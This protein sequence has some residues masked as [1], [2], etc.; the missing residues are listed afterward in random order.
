MAWQN[1]QENARQQG[2][3]TTVGLR[4]GNPGQAFDAFEVSEDQPSLTLG[5][6]SLEFSTNHPPVANAGANK[7]VGSGAPFT[8]DGS[9]STDP[10]GTAGLLFQWTQ[11]AGPVTTIKDPN[12]AEAQVTGVKG[13]ATLTYQLRVIDPFGRASFDTVTMTVSKPK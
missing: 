2:S 12:K 10:D 8:L 11:T 7:T 3:S 6:A 1:G 9:G 5:T 13:P 4:N